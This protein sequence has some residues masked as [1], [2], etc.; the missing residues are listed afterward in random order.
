M[1]QYNR[2]SRH[3]GRGYSPAAFTLSDRI[4][5]TALTL[6]RR[7]RRLAARAAAAAGKGGGRAAFAVFRAAV[8]EPHSAPVLPCFYHGG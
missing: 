5:A 6:P 8:A 7:L 1:R 3:G 2:H 4:N